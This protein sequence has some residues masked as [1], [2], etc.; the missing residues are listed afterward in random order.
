[1]TPK[2]KVTT[3]FRKEQSFTI[4]EDEAHKAYYLFLNPTK[5][6]IFKD[7]RAVRG[8]DIRE[9]KPDYNATMGWNEGYELGPDDYADIKEKGA[10]RLCRSILEEAKQSAY[11]MLDTGNE[12]LLTKP[13]NEVF[14]LSSGGQIEDKLDE[15]KLPEIDRTQ[16]VPLKMK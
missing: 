16:L 2:I 1:M 11:Y 5:R 7:G 3:G 8:E 6:A 10:D 4:G 13:M 15:D 12:I 14:A 9:I